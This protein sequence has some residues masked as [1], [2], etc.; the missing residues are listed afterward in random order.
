MRHFLVIFF[1]LFSSI[2]RAEYFKHIGMSNGLSQLSVL[3]IYQDSL[4]RMWFGTKEGIG[5]YDGNSILTFKAYAKNHSHQGGVTQIDNDINTIQGDANGNIFLLAR[6]SLIKYDIYKETTRAITT[7]NTRAIASYEGD[8]WCMVGQDLFSY[9]NQTDSLDYVMHTAIDNATWLTITEDQFYISSRRGLYAID[10]KTKKTRCLIA[11]VDVYRTF[12]SS[13]KELWVGCRM[14]GLY[15]ISPKGDI[16]KVPYAPNSPHGV[17]SMQIRDFSEDKHHNIW[18]GTFDGLQKFNYQT[19]EYSLI[20]PNKQTGGPEHPSIF[21]VYKDRQG[22]IWLGTYYGGV[23]YFDPGH[24]V[25]KRYNYDQ[26]A[27]KDLYFSYIG[28]MTEDRDGNL[29]FCTDGGG[30]SSL[31]RR[32]HSY[33]N[34]KAGSGNNALPHNNVKSICYDAKRHQLYIGTYLGGLSRFDIASGSFY[35]YHQHPLKGDKPGNIV[36]HVVFRNDRLYLSS[37]KGF[38]EMNPETNEF[39][40]LESN[41]Y[42]QN[43]DVDD[44]GNAWLL[45]WET[46]M[47]I[48]LHNPKEVTEIHLKKY[49]CNFQLTKVKATPWG[50]YFGTLGSGMFF[51]DTQ[52][53]QISN[54]NVAKGQLLSDYCYSISVTKLGNILLT[55]EKG[56]TL[57]SPISKTFRSLELPLDFPAPAII[58]DCGT[59]V[60]SDNEIYIGDIKGFTS[61]YENDLGMHNSKMK[62]YFSKLSV[63]NQTIYPDDETGILSTSLPFNRTL[64]L[65]HNQNNLTVNFAISN[66]SNVQQS[67][68]EYK[69]GGFDKQWIPTK[70]MSLHYT[71]LDPGKYTLYVRS[72]SNGFNTEI[73]EISLPIYISSPWYN[74]LWSW[75]IYFSV[76]SSCVYYYFR[77]RTARKRLALSLEKEQFEKKQIEQMNQAKL[78]FFTNVSHEFRTP[79][80]LIVSH[81]DQLLQRTN[82]PVSIYN[83]MLKVRKNAQQMTN[84]VSELLDFRKF[85]QNSVVLK[86]ANQDIVA[87]LKEIYYSF[88]EYAQQRNIT[89]HFQNSEEVIVCWFDSQQMEKVFF[90]ILS[91]A[92]KY[93]PDDGCIELSVTVGDDLCVKVKDSGTGL[94]QNEV[95]RIFDRFYQ[96]DNKQRDAKMNPGTGIGLALTKS[97]IEKHHGEIQVESE[98]GKGS[99]FVIHLQKGKEHFESDKVTLLLNQVEEKPCMTITLPV[100]MEL[101][102][103]GDEGGQ[104]SEQ[105]AV[106]DNATDT[107]LIVEDNKELLAV[108]KQLF[109]PFYKTLIAYNG[110]EGLELAIS[111]KPNLIVSDIM[112]PE[113][114]GTEMCLQI[115]NDVDLCHI[116]VIL[117]TA[118]NTSE[119]NIEGLNSGADDYIT[120]PFDA[121]ILLARCHNLIKNRLLIQ[122]QFNEKSVYDIDL[123]SFNPLDKD[124]LKRTIEIVDAHLDDSKFDIPMLCK[125]IG[126]GR[127][128]LYSKLKAL[129]G[130]TPNNFIL[131]HKLKLACNI[132]LKYPNLQISEVA[133][134][135]GFGSAVYFTRC[136]K[137][138]YDESPQSYRKTHGEQKR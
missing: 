123:T 78:L 124:L 38:F 44:K 49:G 77:S 16:A 94:E 92:F 20:R 101:E 36:Y 73:E 113:M 116:P 81:I 107:I 61:F 75:L 37:N 28:E 136:F 97:I 9:N 85:E 33:S 5:V 1:L 65:K 60:S 3:S 22:C 82:L 34:F 90:N 53:K 102:S 110:K 125:E 99:T 40:C 76:T 87:F 72:K 86:V 43:F 69:L 108:I 134:Q 103:E 29:W 95:N 39:K 138:E 129:T 130:M 17:S 27:D 55:C 115:K 120:K 93:T 117:L 25:F 132:L 42:C 35:N 88:Y 58:N 31:N 6:Y 91:N 19:G 26:S 10:R 18:F 23:N 13:Q 119:Q 112:M 64:T 126:V 15:R 74:S 66:Y 135:L 84:L 133:D 114:T 41:P 62:L 118:L 48:N 7:G 32:T 47:C 4:G 83:H 70:Y 127:T 96:A 11:D 104:E 89:Y 79:L 68:Y 46:L 21:A 51:Y 67:R 109:S 8:I 14:E 59:F 106:A 50:V 121:K 122:Q 80:T 56:I 128:L 137:S 30:F 131:N 24:E 57:F 71:N 105:I 12:E 54:Y 52:T 45:F 63:N 111:E 98:K 100:D 2:T